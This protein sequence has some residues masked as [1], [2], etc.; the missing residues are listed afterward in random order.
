MN[1]RNA[2]NPNPLPLNAASVIGTAGSG[3][4]TK[5]EAWGASRAAGGTPE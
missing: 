3:M 1:Q 2:Q 5:P 4:G